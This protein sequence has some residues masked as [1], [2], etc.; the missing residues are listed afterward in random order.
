M[1]KKIFS[2]VIIIL[3]LAACKQPAKNV[4]TY[5]LLVPQDAFDFAYFKLGS[6]WIYQDSVSHLI[7]STYVTLA[8]QGINTYNGD[9]AQT[10]GYGGKFG[11]F[12]LNIYSS[13]ERVTYVKEVERAHSPINQSTTTI[14]Y[15]LTRPNQLMKE[16]I[17]LNIPYSLNTI[18]QAPTYVFNDSN[19]VVR[20]NA[21]FMFNS[22]MLLNV[23]EIHQAHNPLCNNLR[24]KTFIKKG[25]GILRKEIPDSNRV[26]NLIRCNIVQ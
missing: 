26:W 8:E 13:Y 25:Y 3:F 23:L 5:N 17:Y 24:T 16:C 11:Y 12:Y 1:M 7:D 20:D 2:W 18:V 14:V 6:Y 21:S 4:P 10:M 9:A 15:H 19:V 22:T